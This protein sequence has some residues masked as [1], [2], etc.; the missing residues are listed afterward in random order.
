[1]A[2]SAAASLT[3]GTSEAPDAPV[4]SSLSGYIIAVG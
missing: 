1:V 2:L 3:N 4:P